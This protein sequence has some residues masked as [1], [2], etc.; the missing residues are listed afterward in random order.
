MNFAVLGDFTERN[1][2]NYK[3]YFFL[4]L[5]SNLTKTAFYE[6]LKIDRFLSLAE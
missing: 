6:A 2:T 1:F 4:I 5:R 3:I